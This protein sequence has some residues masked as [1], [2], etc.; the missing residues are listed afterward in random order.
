MAFQ[1]FPLF[2]IKRNCMLKW[3]NF[4]NG[5]SQLLT[6]YREFFMCFE[7][8]EHTRGHEKRYIYV[9]IWLNS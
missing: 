9:C 6:A 7:G 2:T 8:S 1:R 5:N 3:G 4:H